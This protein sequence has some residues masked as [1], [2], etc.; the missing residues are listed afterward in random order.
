MKEK[1][2]KSQKLRFEDSMLVSC[3]EISPLVSDVMIDVRL[4]EKN[5][6]GDLIEKSWIMTEFKDFQNKIQFVDLYSYDKSKGYSSLAASILI[7]LYKEIIE[8]ILINNTICFGK[9]S[10][11]GDENPQEK[12][13]KRKI[14]W[15]ELGFN[16]ADG[17]YYDDPSMRN[18]LINLKISPLSRKVT[19]DFFQLSKYK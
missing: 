2:F 7:E 1:Y 8:P 5:T 17:E 3:I 15:S 4:F 14:F 6:N 16:V 11:N 19:N 10:S 9:L 13:K 18:H 12:H